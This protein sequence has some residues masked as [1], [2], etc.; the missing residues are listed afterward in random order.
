MRSGW[1]RARPQDDSLL[2]EF[3]FRALDLLVDA[4]T[5]DRLVVAGERA[6]PR[7]DGIVEPRQ[8]EQ[9]VAVVI[10]DDRVRLELIGRALQVV[11][12]ERQLVGLVVRPTEAVEIRAVVR[13]NR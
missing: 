13:L 4:G 2:A 12:R 1:P 11:E 9:H 3:L 7:G 6:R 5:I 10:L 8:L